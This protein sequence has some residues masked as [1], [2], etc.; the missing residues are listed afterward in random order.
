MQERDC[1]QAL[2]DIAGRLGHL[3]SETRI[4]LELLDHERLARN[5]Y[6]AGDAA[7]RRE[8]D[9]D[10][11]ARALACDSLE[12]ELVGLVVVQEDRGGLG[13]EDRAGALDDRLQQLAVVLLR[14]ERSRR[15]R[16]AKIAHR[17]PPTLFAVR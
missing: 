1:H 14:A 8:P 6:P 9:A 4:L 7:A 3:A 10:Q 2:R 5:E 11:V 12:D 15:D 13:A 17:P 16:C